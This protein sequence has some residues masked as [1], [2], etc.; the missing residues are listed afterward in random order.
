MSQASAVAFE[1]FPPERDAKRRVLLDAVA[2]IADVLA[3]HRDESEELRTLAPASVQALHDVGLT[4]LKSPLEVGGAEADPVL[5]MDVIEA[6]TMI[7][8]AAAW[9]MF[10]SSA[11]TGGALARLPD[12]A[13]AEMLSG[14][15]FPFMAGSLRPGGEARAVDGGYRISGRWGWGSG[16][17]H[18]DFV[19]VPVFTAEREVIQAVVPIADVDAQDNWHVLGMKGTGSSDYVLDDVFVPERFVTHPA[20]AT[21]QRGGRLF[22]LG[23]PG[24][25]IN[26]HGAFA[27][28]LA[29]LALQ[30]STE[31]AVEKKRGYVGGTSIAD[32][33]VFQRAIAEG[34]LRVDASRLLMVDTLER[35]FDA[36]EHGIPPA[37][38]QA[39]T[40][41]AAVL[42]TDEA[43][44]V[45]SDLFRYAGGSAVQLSHRLQ[46]VLRD[47]FTVQSHLVVS[48]SAYE[49]Y[50]Q[51][52]LG[53]SDEAPLK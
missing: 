21:Q 20:T 6:V 13:V 33:A 16:V 15:R 29:R 45:T 36:A 7:D 34:K 42:C 49:I 11:V 2:S 51:L 1:G 8:P 53:L 4:R 14:E 40:R 24:Y 19:S 3:A 46:R 47:L 27:Y 5:Q 28:A 52:L 48:D 26:E 31:M 41:A 22:R 30:I 12:E 32:R 44:A 18:A 43:L 17:H 9:S 35:L 38:L 50:G 25:V 39:E 37:P 10:I 23:M